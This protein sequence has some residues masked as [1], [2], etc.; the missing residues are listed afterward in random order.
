[1]SATLHLGQSGTRRVGMTKYNP[2]GSL[3]GDR[4]RQSSPS[5]L[6][7]PKG[8]SSDEAFDETPVHIDEPSDESEFGGGEKKEKPDRNGLPTR[9]TD[10]TSA[11][12]E[13]SKK[14]R[15]S[16]EPSNIKPSIFTSGKGLGDCNGSQSSQKGNSADLEEEILRSFSQNQRKKPRQ[17]YG[18]GS[19]SKKRGTWDSASKPGNNTRMSPVENE[20]ARRSFKNPPSTAMIA[21]HRDLLEDARPSFKNPPS[22]AMMAQRRNFIGVGLFQYIRLT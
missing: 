15:L 6:A 19:A 14:R 20:K 21:Q 5:I 13:D 12:S 18:H 17:S 1:M 8:S 11:N 4:A 10:S 22:T 7:S 16:G 9:R 2:Y 3:H